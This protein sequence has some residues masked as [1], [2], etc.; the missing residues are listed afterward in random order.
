MRFRTTALLATAALALGPALAGAVTPAAAADS[1]CEPL[2][3]GQVDPDGTPRAVAAIAPS[4]NLITGYCVTSTAGAASYVT[5]AAPVTWVVVRSAPGLGIAHYSYA[6]APTDTTE[7]VQPGQFPTTTEPGPEIDQT[8]A[9][10]IEPWSWDWQY[11]APTCDALTVAYPANIQDHLSGGPL[12]VNIRF[13]SNLGR[14]TFNYHNNDNTHPYGGVTSF[15]YAQHPRYPASGLRW[16]TVEWTSVHG[17]NYEW[18][19]AVNCVVNADGSAETVD[20]PQAVTTISGFNAS[21]VKVKKGKK[22]GADAIVLD[23]TDLAGVV[24]QRL[25]GGVWRTVSTI[26]T[27]DGAAR[28]VFPKETRKGTYAYRLVSPESEFVTG[29]VSDVLTVKVVKP[30]KKKH[31]HR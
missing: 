17:T 7:V 25:G 24:L 23:Q 10:A 6:W 2:S 9:P 22:L 29:A 4:G 20:V 28:I 1:A 5:L 12:D 3:S 15:V 11:A 16:F 21:T 14:D 18:R 26:A 31:R 13:N 19:G 8:P 30:K 27:S